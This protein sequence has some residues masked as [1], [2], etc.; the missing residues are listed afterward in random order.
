MPHFRRPL[1]VSACL[2]AL[3]AAGC[4]GGAAGQQGQ[5]VGEAA[6]PAS[7]LLACVDT[8]RNA[9]CDDADPSQGVTSA[10]ATGLAPAPD[11][12]VLVEARDARNARTALLVSDAG[13]AQ[14]DGLSTLRAMLGLPVGSPLERALIA[15]NGPQ[16]AQVLETG[17]AA[18]AA[19]DGV[20]LPALARFAAAVQAQVS[21]TPTLAAYAPALG[22]P[23]AVAA[24]DDTTGGSASQP[25]TVYTSTVLGNDDS[26][27]L[28]ILDSDAA[29]DALSEVDLIP[30]PPPLALAR[31]P[32]NRWLAA[33]D[34]VVSIFVDTAS[35]ASSVS[36][37]PTSPPVKLNPGQGIAAAQ[38][39]HA[40]A[41][42]VVLLNLQTGLYNDATCGQGR[43]GI[44]RVPLAPPNATR[45]MST[46]PVC[47]HSGF[48]LLAADPAGASIAAWDTNASTL[49]S[50]DGST[51]KER[52]VL[53][54]Q[55]T[56]AQALAVSP[57]GR[58]A[59]VAAPGL[60]EIVDLLAG[61]V[62]ANLSGPWA[63]VQ[64]VAFAGG[65]RRLVI[66]SGDTLHVV[67]FDEG[68]RWVDTRSTALDGPLRS[69]AIAPDGDSLVAA[70]DAGLSWH[71]VE[72]GDALAS[73][74]LP[75]GL[76]VQHVAVGSDH[77]VVTGLRTAQG[78]FEVDSAAIPLAAVPQ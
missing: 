30:A 39:T 73:A 10:G 63:D 8:N 3:A 65:V 55:I 7:G 69:F 75:A 6:P 77:L 25:M 57:G 36:G 38:I 42:A 48:A 18:T 16:V 17:F 41:E 19:A 27:R 35:A 12:R 37:D 5:T 46:E 29:Q 24:W 2:L 44:Y 1:I 9:Q 76:D 67:A 26:N 32:A 13:S 34:R 71:T 15:A 47:A 20:L 78:R 53:S 61:Q 23:A 72:T 22:A 74:P 58:F 59:A 40:G 64:G 4:G 43:E 66:G 33:L 49:W 45:D 62:V 28:F 31:K 54:L 68:M 21:A 50:I 51:M 14:A 70:T 60:V 52:A 11:Q 56:A